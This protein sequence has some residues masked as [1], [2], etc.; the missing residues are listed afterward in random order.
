[1][2]TDKKILSTDIRTGWV[3]FVDYWNSK[4]PQ[5]KNINV[6]RVVTKNP[7][8]SNSTPGYIIDI[9]F[10]I[11]NVDNYMFE[12][13]KKA[14]SYLKWLK[15]HSPSLMGAG[16]IEFYNMFKDFQPDRFKFNIVKCDVVTRISKH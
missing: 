10:I 2:K 11:S 9:D 14:G 16:S 1:M 8:W 12:T 13:K 7:V 3:I 4:N 15:C 5:T 6:T